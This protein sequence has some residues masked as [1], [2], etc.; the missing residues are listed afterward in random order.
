MQICAAMRT[1]RKNIT[2]TIS[3]QTYRDV[4][5]WCA[6]RNASISEVVEAYFRDVC[7]AH[8]KPPTP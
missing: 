8:Y 3:Q 7:R 4:R 6:R 5:V 1:M 2:V